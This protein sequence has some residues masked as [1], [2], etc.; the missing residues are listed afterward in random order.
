MRRPTLVLAFLVFA[1]TTILWTRYF[2]GVS[3]VQDYHLMYAVFAFVPALL[4]CLCLAM[5]SI[6][7][8]WVAWAG[9]ILSL[10]TG[11]LWILSI[12]LIL[13][14]YKIH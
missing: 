5:L 7:P 6:R 13:S 1:T 3:V 9:G 10:P 12:M 4:F 14:D 8:L 2:V 11:A